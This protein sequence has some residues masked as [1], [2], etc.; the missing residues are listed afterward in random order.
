MKF[1][2]KWFTFYTKCYYTPL[3]LWRE[4]FCWCILVSIQIV[5]RAKSWRRIW[6]SWRRVE[7]KNNLFGRA[8]TKP[9]KPPPTP[10]I[11]G[12]M[13]KARFYTAP[14]SWCDCHNE[15]H[16]GDR[17]DSKPNT[18][19]NPRPTEACPLPLYYVPDTAARTSHKTH[20]HL[21][22]GMAWAT[23]GTFWTSLLTHKFSLS[24]KRPQNSH[25][26]PPPPDAKVLH[27]WI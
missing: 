18:W 21:W 15:W 16:A 4:E 26:C 13:T 8:L 9:T 10:F 5:Y 19:C 11:R 2:R 1:W 7:P 23:S 24:G 12:M 3:P 6:K 20:K 17:H 27:Q 14:C 22:H 25:A